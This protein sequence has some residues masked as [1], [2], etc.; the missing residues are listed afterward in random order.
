MT[1][2]LVEDEAATKA[3]KNPE[4]PVRFGWIKGVMV[5]RAWMGCPG[6]GV[7]RQS[8]IRAQL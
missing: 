3:E 7:E 1:D 4:E 6:K 2:G 5:S 8:S